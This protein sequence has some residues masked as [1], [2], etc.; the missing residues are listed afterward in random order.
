M[1]LLIV[2]SLVAISI[3]VIANRQ[4]TLDG[5]K[6]GLMM[7]IK[8]LPTLVNVLI[9]VSIF[10]YLIPNEKWVE[11]MDESSGVEGYIIAGV[12]G[13]LSLIPGFIAFPLSSVLIKS[14]VSYPVLAMFITTLLMVGVFTLPIEMQYFGWRVS[15]LRNGLS[16]V[17]A[18]ICALIIGLF[19]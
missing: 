15:L 11:W 6:R 1:K 13:S 19:Y 7:F 3:S 5:L 14:G 9:L 12:T 8:L 18:V 2:V 16:L 4:K 10:L 17:G